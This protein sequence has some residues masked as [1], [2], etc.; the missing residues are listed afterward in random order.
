MRPATQ[1]LALPG[2]GMNNLMFVVDRS[3]APEWLLVR[4]E[5]PGR[6]VLAAMSSLRAE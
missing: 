4:R 1:R 5:F 6:L 3:I 2:S